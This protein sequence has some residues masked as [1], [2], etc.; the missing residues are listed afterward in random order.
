M[1]IMCCMTWHTTTQI[2]KSLPDL[3]IA[4]FHANPGFPQQVGA[5]DELTYYTEL[6]KYM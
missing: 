6:N 4:F 5:T 3:D 1:E 2:I